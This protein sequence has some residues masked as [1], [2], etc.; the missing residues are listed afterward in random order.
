MLGMSEQRVHPDA[1]CIRVNPDRRPKFPTFCWATTR[2]ATAR[3][4]RPPNVDQI[5]FAVGATTD[6]RGVESRD[7]RLGRRG[8]YCSAIGG[9]V[10]RGL[11][12]AMENGNRALRRRRRFTGTISVLVQDLGAGFRSVRAR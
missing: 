9:V 7:R 5:P 1:F 8:V 10:I 12:S 2:E 11:A 6:G 3:S 4:T